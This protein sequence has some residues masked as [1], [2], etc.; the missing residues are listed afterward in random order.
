[1]IN[2]K[3]NPVNLGKS[4]PK[5]LLLSLLGDNISYNNEIMEIAKNPKLS[6]R[7]MVSIIIR[8]ILLLFY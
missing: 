6:N 8:K 5:L 3:L 2:N 1:M 4:F 7:K